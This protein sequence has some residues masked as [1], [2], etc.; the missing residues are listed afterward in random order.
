MD[1]QSELVYYKLLF[2]YNAVY[3]NKIDYDRLLIKLDQILI[4]IDGLEKYKNYR[5]LIKTMAN[6]II[7]KCSY[8]KTKQD[9]QNYKSD[10]KKWI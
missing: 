9:K 2:K 1:E 10:I 5:Q 6:N 3:S 4:L 7:V 8:Y